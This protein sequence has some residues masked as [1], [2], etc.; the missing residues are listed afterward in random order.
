MIA[1]ETIPKQRLFLN[2]AI[3][4]ALIG[5]LA[6]W[7]GMSLI[8]VD[9]PFIGMV[10]AP[11]WQGLASAIMAFVFVL[12]GVYL[13]S[14][15][16]NLLAPRFAAEKDSRQALK[17][18]IYSYTPAGLMGIFGIL[19]MFSLVAILGGLYGFYL[20]YLG[21]PVLMRC[22]QEKAMAYTAATITGTLL[23]SFLL[24]LLSSA[25]R[26]F[27]NACTPMGT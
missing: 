22:P 19:P 10:R 14:I 8:G 9:L 2:Y 12:A 7:L 1:N 25:F 21:L 4:L 17:I 18:V 23:I 16:I 11:Y 6:D 26:V 5:P 15:I 27:L 13:V 3:P 24:A 20:L